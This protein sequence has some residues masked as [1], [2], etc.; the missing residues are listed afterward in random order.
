MKKVNL[1]KIIGITFV[2]LF[3]YLFFF[4]VTQAEDVVYVDAQGNPVVGGGTY[5]LLAPIPGLSEAPSNI[6]DYF[7][8][9]F[10]IAIGLCGALAV[11]MIIIGGVQYM[12]KDSVFGKT[13]ARNRILAAVLGLLIA[14]GSY[15]LLNT[16]NPDLLGTG[17]VNIAQV[18]AE[19][20]P[21]IVDPSSTQSGVCLTSVATAAN[22]TKCSEG[23]VPIAVYD[24]GSF[25]YVCNSTATR[26]DTSKLPAMLAAANSAGVKLGGRGLRSYSQQQCL[27]E[28]NNCADTSIPPSQCSPDDVAV[29]GTS[30]HEYGLAIDFTCNGLGFINPT[31]RPGTRVCFD[32]LRANAG[33]YG[34]SNLPSEPW[35]WSTNG[36]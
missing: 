15:A 17:G 12:G 29:P 27:R 21:E 16:I 9:I 34:F 32:W 10:K 3:S 35:H 31:E 13:E 22:S 7:N 2:F 19:I 36:K 26:R 6:G 20:D 28:Q 25:I 30:N 18:M 11:V 1:Y 23:T 14:L 5:Q 33:A 4:G 24:S 8:T